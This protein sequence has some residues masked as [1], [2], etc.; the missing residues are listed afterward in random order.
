MFKIFYS[1]SDW[2]NDPFFLPAT[3]KKQTCQIKMLY[4]ELTLAPRAFHSELQQQTNTVSTQKSPPW[5]CGNGCVEACAERFSALKF[6]SDRPKWPDRSLWTTFKAGPEY[7]G[8]TKPK[9]SVPFDE[10]TEI[11]GILGWM[12]SGSVFGFWKVFWILGIVLDSGK[13]FWILG[14]VL[15]TGKCFWIL[16]IVLDTG[17]C[18][19]LTSHRSKPVNKT[20]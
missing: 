6:R 19:V 17:K 12:D 16:G 15:D 7:S 4:K 5:A 11:S 2:R 18:F 9:W 14:I 13:C 1:T 10:P 8:R 3:K 20:S